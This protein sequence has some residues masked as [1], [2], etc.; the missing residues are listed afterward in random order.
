MLG[1]TRKDRLVLMRVAG[2][3]NDIARF[4]RLFVEG[5]IS[6]EKANE[7]YRRGIAMK[8]GGVPCTCI[9]CQKAGN[10]VIQAK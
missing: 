5:R 1:D 3:H 2:Y 8:K 10:T 4:T 6:L 7:E 9:D